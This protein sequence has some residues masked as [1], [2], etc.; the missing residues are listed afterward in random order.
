[1]KTQREDAVAK[2]ILTLADKRRWAMWLAR[3]HD[4]SSG[5]WL[6]LGKKTSGVKSIS[7]GDA[8]DVA[9]C[10]GW[11]DGQAKSENERFWVVKFTPRGR[12]SL[13]SK[14]NREKAMALIASGDMTPS[15][16]AEVER[17][18]SDGRWDRAY[19]PPSRITVPDDLQAALDGNKRAERFFRTL[20]GQN[21]YAILFRIQTAHRA[22]TRARR[23]RQFVE[24][25]SRHEKIYP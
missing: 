15:G 6:R 3:N 24:M 9:L 8:L 1:M 12:R 17:A 25:L 18:K 11:I 7:H 10:F 19:D 20:N 2:P 21:R 13:W 4:T 14:R 5:V 16:L 23:I 22:E